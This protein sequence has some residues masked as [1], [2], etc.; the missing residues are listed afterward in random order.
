MLP[1]PCCSDPRRRQAGLSIV[2][3]MVGMVIG[4]IASLVIMQSFSSSEAY[5]RNISGAGDALQ[6]AAIAAQRLDLIIQEA[7]AGL[8]RGGQWVWGCRLRVDYKSNAILPSGSAYPAPFSSIPQTLRAVP[9]AIVSGGTQDSDVIIV[10]AGD[11][12]SGNQGKYFSSPAGSSLVTV[13][14]TIGVGLKSTAAAADF[15]L[16]LTLQRKVATDPGDCRVVQA[17]STMV[18]PTVVS[19]A[20]LGLN[21]V[22]FN[23]LVPLN[24]TTYGTMESS[25]YEGKSGAAF[26]LG[27]RDTPN[28]A[29]LGV[30]SDSEL[31]QYDLLQRTATQVVGENIFLIKARYG[32]DNGVGGEINDNAVDEWVS[33]SE[34]GW[35]LAD[36]MDGKLATQQR[37]GYIKAIRIAMVVRSSQPIASQSPMTSIKLFQDLGSSRQY[38]RSLTSDEQRYQ[39]QVYEW[40]IPLRN[41]RTP[42]NI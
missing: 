11:S 35:T 8:A 42:P 7:G 12:A 16:I 30:N 20:S 23:K 1:K 32:L 21:V 22:T 18:A 33:P 41:M 36:L 39:Y 28:F 2:E 15:D 5:R 17:A 34:S 40:V 10:M 26:H 24:T 6:S 31:L 27:L 4:L 19:D 25:I 38:S 29:M 37:I 13:S 14:P 9:A 3:M